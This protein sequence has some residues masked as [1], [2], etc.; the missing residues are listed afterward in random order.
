MK[1]YLKMKETSIPWLGKIP[2]HWGVKPIKNISKVQRGAS[3][4][5]IDDPSYF[6]DAGEFSWVRISDVSASNG[7]LYN[8]EQKLSESGASCSVKRYPGDLFLSIAGTV[9]K[10]CILGIKACIHDG[11]VYFD[12]LNINVWLLYRIFEAGYCYK[13]LGKLGTQLNLNTDTV[14][15]IRIPFPPLDEQRAIAEYLDKTTAKIDGLI[16]AQEH[17]IEL[18]AEKRKALISHVVTKGLNPKAKLKD[19][20]V[21]WLGKV[22]EHWVAQRVKFCYTIQLGKMLQPE[23][24]SPTDEETTY[25]KSQH[26]Q[27]GQVRME[28][29]PTMWTNK[30][31]RIQYEVRDGDLLV[32]EGGDVGRAAIVHSSPVGLIIQ[33]ALHRVRPKNKNKAE[34]LLYV[35]AH[36]TSHGWFD[37]IC[38]KST[39]AHFTVDKFGSLGIA[40]PPLDEQ[41]A[42]VEYLDKATAKLDALA[43][44]AEEAIVLMKERRS[45]LI[46][47]VVTGK[48]KVS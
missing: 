12:K 11:F 33:N 46:S 25:L 5:P 28:E 26:V 7:I 4:R 38:N 37:I 23:P 9:G 27:W 8:T 30:K 10:P 34:L 39:I 42:I 47:A 29:L 43:A 3:P 19:S 36:A 16:A 21:P 14:G 44:K 18:L 24:D 13:G 17:L 45:A 6:D 15:M 2:E 31:E 32:C 20:G 22:P 41:R 40:L 48:V 35:L 1:T